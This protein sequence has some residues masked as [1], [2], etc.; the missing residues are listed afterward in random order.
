[1]SFARKVSS[2]GGDVLQF[3]IDGV[4]QGSWSGTQDWAVMTYSMPAGTHTLL[5][6]YSG[7]A[8][9]WIDSVTLP[10]TQACLGQRCAPR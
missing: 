3:F 5:W 8:A 7:G 2:Q 1:V 9:A 6:R 4:L 10:G